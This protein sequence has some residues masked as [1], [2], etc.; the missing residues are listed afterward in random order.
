MR[1][2]G[3]TLREIGIIMGGRTPQQVHSMLNFVSLKRDPVLIAM[4]AS[5]GDQTEPPP[6][7]V[8]E[9]AVK[10]LRAPRTST[11][12]ICGDPVLNQCALYRERY[13]ERL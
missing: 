6:A 5:L 8:I 2:S 11:M 3:A 12:I 4:M 13:G 7:Y 1:A 9:E 10:R